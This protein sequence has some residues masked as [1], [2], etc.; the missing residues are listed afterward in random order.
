[1]AD[2]KKRIVSLDMTKN[3]TSRQVPLSS[4]AIELLKAVDCD[5]NL[6]TRQIDSTFRSFRDKAMIENLHFHDSRHQAI[7][8]LAKKM[9][10]LDLTRMVGIKDLKILMVYY[11]E[12]DENIAKLLD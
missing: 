10:V 9:D 1:M 6:S 5:F 7:T 2:L 12:S 8:N 11:N 3:G 4:R